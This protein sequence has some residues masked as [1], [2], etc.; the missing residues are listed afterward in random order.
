MEN[1]TE[2]ELKIM[3][4]LEEWKYKSL[5][6]KEL[7]DMKEM[8]QIAAKNTLKRLSERKAISIRVFKSDINKIK[9]IALNEGIP[10]QTFITSILHKFAKWELKNH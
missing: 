9:S 4:D 7:E 2:E 10:Y 1:Y 3:K 5:E 8:L 6:W